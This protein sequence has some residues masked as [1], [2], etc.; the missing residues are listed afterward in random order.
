ME[1][2]GNFRHEL[3]YQIGA[4]EHIALR[5]RLGCV[6]GRDGHARGDGLYLVRS[7]YFDPTP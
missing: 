1:L 6:M 2:P 7:I 3:K 5:S 4:A